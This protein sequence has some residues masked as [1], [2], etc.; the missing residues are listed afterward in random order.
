MKLKSY[1]QEYYQ[2][3]KEAILAKARIRRQKNK[4]KRNAK[5][6]Q[7]RK[8]LREAVLNRLSD[9]S[10]KCANCGFAHPKNWA[11]EIDHIHAGGNK[12]IRRFDPHKY[13]KHFLTM[14]L[15]ELKSNY[16]ILCANCNFIKRRIFKEESLGRK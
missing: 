13:L 1:S 14:S 16:Q 7:Y 15:E 2:K 9:G 8:N 12:E 4:K 11:L 6:R 5:D 10:P 3:N